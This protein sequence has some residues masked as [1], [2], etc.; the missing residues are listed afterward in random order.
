MITI[1]FKIRSAKIKDI[2]KFL[3]KNA[4]FV[5]EGLIPINRLDLL[6]EEI[7]IIKNFK[8]GVN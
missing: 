3:K 1:N 5:I 4:N 2:P 7:K 6:K 8:K